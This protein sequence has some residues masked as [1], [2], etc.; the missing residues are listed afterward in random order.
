[1]GG[2]SVS[3]P[4]SIDWCQKSLTIKLIDELRDLIVSA[5]HVRCERFFTRAG[6]FQAVRAVAVQEKEY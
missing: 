6:L 3:S 4:G 5:V 1:M 2:I